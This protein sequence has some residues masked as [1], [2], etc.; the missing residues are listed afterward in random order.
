MGDLFSRRQGYRIRREIRIRE[1]APPEL[2]VALIAV[3]HDLGLTYTQ[4]RGIICPVL[5]AIPDRNNWT[6]VPNVRDEVVALV[7]GCEW[8]RVYDICEA[9]YRY[10]RDE[11]HALHRYDR[12]NFPADEFTNRLNELFEELGIGWQMIEGRIVTRGPEEFERA[13]IVIPGGLLPQA[14][15]QI[16][17]Y[18]TG[19]GP[20]QPLL[21]RLLRYAESIRFSF[22]TVI[23]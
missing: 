18:P 17:H 9:A 2:R 21:H 16:H 5:H 4:I 1:D 23:T 3:L 8:F 7:Q 13:R 20:T 10:L 19:Q 14:Q 11:G 22:A 12:E 15:Q 6:K